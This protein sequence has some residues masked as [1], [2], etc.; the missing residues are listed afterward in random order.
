MPGV[1]EPFPKT[2]PFLA[3]LPG[4]QCFRRVLKVG[5]A[6]NSELISYCPYHLSGPVACQSLSLLSLEVDSLVTIIVNV[7]VFIASGMADSKGLRNIKA[8]MLL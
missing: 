6:V 4:R 8:I 7:N 2:L 5:M 3:L 1:F